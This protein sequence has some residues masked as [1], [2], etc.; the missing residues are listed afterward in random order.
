MET[1]TDKNPINDAIASAVKALK[2]IMDDPTVDPRIR[3]RAA[4]TLKTYCDKIKG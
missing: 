4:R 1:K 3:V 2:E